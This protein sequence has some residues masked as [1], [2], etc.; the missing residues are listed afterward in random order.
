MHRHKW[1]FSDACSIE[2]ACDI[3]VGLD[4]TL[5]LES[6]YIAVSLKGERSWALEG[7]SGLLDHFYVH[8]LRL[9]TEKGEVLLSSL[10]RRYLD[11]ALFRGRLG[12]HGLVLVDDRYAWQLQALPDKC[13]RTSLQA[14]FLGRVEASNLVSS[15]VRIYQVS[16]I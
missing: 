8:E 7:L 4:L 10:A 13:Q 15:V 16:H 11:L 2:I 3:L 6:G 12:L 14:S 9:R 5:V 1:T